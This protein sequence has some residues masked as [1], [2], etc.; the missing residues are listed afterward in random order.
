MKYLAADAFAAGGA[1][2]SSWGTRDEFR[3]TLDFAKAFHM[4]QIVSGC[5]AQGESSVGVSVRC[6]ITYHGLRSDEVGLGPYGDSYWD[7]VVRNGKITSAVP[8]DGYIVNGFSAERWEPFQRWVTSTHP[9]DVPTLYP[10][11]EPTNWDEFIRLWGKRTREWVAA[12]KA[13]SA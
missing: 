8:T 7:F 12:V 4:K 1:G 3:H 11:P 2:G 6:D 13:G 5:E 9:E 10:V